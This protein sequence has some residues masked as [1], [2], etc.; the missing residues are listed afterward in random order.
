MQEELE[1]DPSLQTKYDIQNLDGEPGRIIE[2]VCIEVHLK[3]LKTL[4]LL[5]IFFTYRIWLFMKTQI[6]T[7]QFHL[8]TQ[9]QRQTLK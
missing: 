7:V 6:Q 2:M 5:L 4:L 8:K 9:E 3:L 1:S